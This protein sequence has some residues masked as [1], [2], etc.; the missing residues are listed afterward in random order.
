M[1]AGSSVRLQAVPVSPAEGQSSNACGK[2]TS[3]D[4]WEL[5]GKGIGSKLLGNRQKEQITF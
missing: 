5:G 3:R 4:E 1:L 2:Q